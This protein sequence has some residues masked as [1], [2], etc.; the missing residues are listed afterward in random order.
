M[1]VSEDLKCSQLSQRHYETSKKVSV[2]ETCAPNLKLLPKKHTTADVFLRFC[3]T[4]HC[5]Y[6]YMTPFC[7]CFYVFLQYIQN[8]WAKPKLV[9]RVYSFSATFDVHLQIL[10]RQNVLL[11]MLAWKGQRKSII[12]MLLSFTIRHVT[13]AWKFK[14]LVH[15]LYES[16]F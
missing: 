15:D 8:K 5:N 7:N 14:Y 13:S 1:L 16:Y 12:L 2:L 11:K 4:F 3:K 6:F 9:P 10:E